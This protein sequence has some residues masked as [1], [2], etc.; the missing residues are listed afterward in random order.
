[1][2]K[3]QERIETVKIYKSKQMILTDR[4][5]EDLAGL[6]DDDLIRVYFESTPFGTFSLAVEAVES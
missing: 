2:R 6:N 3:I 1:M 4:D 5:R